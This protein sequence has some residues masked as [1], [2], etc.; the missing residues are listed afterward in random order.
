[1]ESLLERDMMCDVSTKVAAELAV[2][3]DSFKL[4]IGQ[5]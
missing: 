5:M 2:A 1:M 3:C 4:S